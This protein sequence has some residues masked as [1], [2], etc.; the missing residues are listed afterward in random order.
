MK[1]LSKLSI[2]P[3]KVMKN[4]E[5]INLRGGYGSGGGANKIIDCK[6][7]ANPPYADPQPCKW[8]PDSQSLLDAVKKFCVDSSAWTRDC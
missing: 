8:Y 7:G 1:K 5:L 3:K 2:N 6:K 4:E